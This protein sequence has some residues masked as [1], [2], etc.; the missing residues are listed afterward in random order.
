MQTRLIHAT[1]PG[2]IDEASDCL[3]N[4]GLVGLPTETVYGLGADATNGTA[5]ARIFEAKGRPR[6]NPLICHVADLTMA[7]QLISL[8]PVARRLVDR[9][10]PGP[11]T[12][13]APIAEGCPVHPLSCAGLPTL[14]VRMPHGVAREVIARLG[15]PVA[16]PS[17]NPS[18]RVS[19]TTAAAVLAGLSGRID[20]V[21]DGGDCAVG[22]ESTIVRPLEDRIVL[23]RPGGVGRDALADAAGLPVVDHDGAEGIVAP[24]QLRSHYAPAGAV[25]LNATSVEPGEHL[26]KLGPAEVPGEARAVQVINLSPSGSLVEAAA[27]LFAALSAFDDPAIAR[28]A[29]TAVPKTGIGEAINDR[30]MRAAAPRD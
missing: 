4:G 19:P 29:V 12:I 7:R 30:L 2:A 20:L 3:G 25:R 15:R 13:V 14:A 22:L 5:V 17:A 28:I 1:A 24:G 21:L 27:N 16:A 9:F 23:L 8:S 18:G 26:I 10:W 6:F 11:L